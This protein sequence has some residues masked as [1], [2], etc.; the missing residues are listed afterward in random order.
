LF[1]NRK[2]G[3]TNDVDEQ[4]MRDLQLNFFLNLSGHGPNA[5]SPV[6]N[7]PI[8]YDAR[9]EQTSDRG[10]SGSVKKVVTYEAVRSLGVLQPLSDLQHAEACGLISINVIAI[11]FV[12]A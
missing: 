8:F 10:S 7:H 6:S 9:R 4:N 12:I 11:W 2:L 3:V 5:T 1:V